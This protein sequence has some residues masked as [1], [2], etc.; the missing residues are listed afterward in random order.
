MNALTSFVCVEFPGEKQRRRFQDLIR[1]AQLVVLLAQHAD[2]LTL[3]S[4]RLIAAPAAVSFGLAHPLTQRLGVHPEI[5]GDMRDRPAALKRQANT[6]LHELVGVL[7]GSGH[8]RD[9]LS[10]GTNPRNE[11]SVDP[12]L[13]QIVRCTRGSICSPS[14]RLACLRG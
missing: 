2:L 5:G 7:L 11:A 3:R 12:S 4:G 8:D 9:F 10:R 1:P 13:A 14:R 6:S